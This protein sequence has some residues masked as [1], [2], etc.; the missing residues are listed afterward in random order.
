MNDASAPVHHCLPIIP[1]SRIYGGP[2]PDWNGEP[3][4]HR[5]ISISRLPGDWFEDKLVPVFEKFGRIYEMRLLIDNITGLTRN[6][7]MLRYCDPDENDAA[8]RRIDG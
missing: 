2:P 1:G 6:F 8:V 7:C 4:K 3:P 5:E